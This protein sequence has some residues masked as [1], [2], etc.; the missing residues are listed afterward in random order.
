MSQSLH[1]PDW[2]T[3]PAPQD[4]GSADHLTGISVPALTLASTSKAP[5]HLMRLSGTTVIYV[6]PMTGPADG[7]LPQGWDQIPG[8]RGCTPQS[9]AFRDHYDELRRA[10]AS[11]VYGL[12]TQDTSYQQEAVSRLHLP[13][14]ILSDAD[15]RFANSLNLPRFEVNGKILLRRL[16]LIFRAG[17]IAKCFYPVFPPDENAQ[18][19]LTWLKEN[20]SR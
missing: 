17:R 3:I 2:S 8:A 18:I 9:C 14:P 7:T 15:L 19:V 5:V 10:G 1:A 12:S 20:P 16:T 6:Y 13:F 4:D 11:R